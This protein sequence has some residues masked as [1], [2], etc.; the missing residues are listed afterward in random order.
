M[1]NGIHVLSTQHDPCGDD[2]VVLATPK[3]SPL[4]FLNSGRYDFTQNLTRKNLGFSPV[5]QKIF[6]SVLNRSSKF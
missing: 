4:D 6:C 5:L 3:C 1:V 2:K